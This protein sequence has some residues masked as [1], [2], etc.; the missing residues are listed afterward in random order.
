[1]GRGDVGRRKNTTTEMTRFEDGKQI[2]RSSKV[3]KKK[4][5]PKRAKIEP[6]V[7][8]TKPTKLKPV[9]KERACVVVLEEEGDFDDDS[10][11]E[12]RL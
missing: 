1:V 3:I 11:D 12:L 10:D 8:V 6:G 5:E 4:A 9:Q 2:L 7:V